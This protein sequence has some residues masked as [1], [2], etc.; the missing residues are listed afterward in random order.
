MITAL[1]V[2]F[3]CISK[4]ISEIYKLEYETCLTRNSSYL[5]VY[6]HCE[7]TEEGQQ[8]HIK[9]FKGSCTTNSYVYAS[10]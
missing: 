4:F 3:L 6:F 1:R 8:T 7:K 2:S 5:K 10:I 9:Y